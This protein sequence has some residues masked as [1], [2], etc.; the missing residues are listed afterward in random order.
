MCSVGVHRKAQSTQGCK[1]AAHRPARCWRGQHPP[2]VTGRSYGG[3]SR[4]QPAA[5][6]GAA[7]TGRASA[8]VSPNNPS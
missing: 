1:F 3:A 6:Y 2:V 7:G 8:S 5:D 4:V